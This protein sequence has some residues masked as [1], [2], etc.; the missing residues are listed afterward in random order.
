MIGSAVSVQN[1]ISTKLILHNRVFDHPYFFSWVIQNTTR[2][3][4]KDNKGIT[5]QRIDNVL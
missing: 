1:N 4:R 2:N 3:M 5:Y